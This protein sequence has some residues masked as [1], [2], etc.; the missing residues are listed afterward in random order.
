MKIY[1]ASQ[2][3]Y[4]HIGGVSTYLLNLQRELKKRGNDIVELHLRSFN[5]PNHEIIDGIEVHRVPK[6]PLDK[7]MLRGYSK[8]KEAIW[9][10]THGDKGFSRT[11][12][13]ME[14]Y[15][16]FAQIN[17]IFGQEV[18][19][20][21][22]RNTPDLIHIHDFQLLYLYRYVPRGTPLI[23]TWHIPLNKN[24]SSHLK[25]FLFKH[26]I[27][28]DKIVFSSQEYIDTAIDIGIPKEKCE[29]IYPL[30]NTNMFRPLEISRE[31]I[32]KKYNLP[33]DSKIIL[34][35]QRIDN[36]CGHEQLIQALPLILEKEP[37]AK[38]VFVGGHSM[39][40]KISNLRQVY[41][42]RVNNLIKELKLEN[43]IIFTGNVD[44]HDLPDLYNVVDMVTLCSKKEGFGLSVTEGM[45]CGKPIVGTK[46]GGIPLQIID[47]IN[48]YLVDV[49]DYKTTADRISKILTS[50]SLKNQ[51]GNESLE[52]VKNNFRLDF[53]V[54][55]HINL[56]QK[57][58]NEKLEIRRLEKMDINDIDALIT[59]FD[60]TITDEP[61]I[62][63][64]N[65]V[66]EL[67][68]LDTNHILATG[69]SLE[70][71]IKLAKKHDLWQCIVCENGAI[72][73]LPKSE[74]IIT[75]D[76]K[77]MKKARKLLKEKNINATYG[78]VIVS[79]T[80]DVAE[81][82][83]KILMRLRKKLNYVINVDELMIAPKY[84]NK[85]RGVK[86]AL[87]YLELN[88]EKSIVV[89]D[90][91]NDVDLFRIPGFKVAVA[92]ANSRLKLIADQI[93]DN[94]SSK[95]T[96]EIVHKLLPK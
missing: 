83:K 3:F 59:D 16:D 95:G 37:S 74:K 25:K 48:G 24:I 45:S 92:N 31:S 28:Y 80:A 42:D 46:T 86:L 64:K 40:N 23:F 14:G 33:I 89:G 58:L 35:V 61:G 32:L 81:S 39:S 44:Y 56:Y 82:V 87:D 8:F 94:P 60:R 5:A 1:F 17:D 93:T 67:K 68:K 34:C 10:E 12:I 19:D 51:L 54:E 21:L 79:V 57:L 96:I 73:Y 11:P 65:T 69:R 22:N 75:I 41:S 62:L 36:K 47:G 52:I 4:P 38:L 29:L 90:A 9:K 78:S 6:E 26:L 7:H 2:S 55:K 50:E 71:V 91:E 72:I 30:C 20:V 13:E 15:D 84:V 43:N 70:F 77:R 85:G 27:G 88:P 49:G 76:S 63:L 18:R 53:G 66:D